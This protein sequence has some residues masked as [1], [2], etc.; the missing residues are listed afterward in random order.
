M[1]ADGSDPV[2]RVRLMI[3]EKKKV[4]PEKVVEKARAC[5]ILSTRGDIYLS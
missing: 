4:L 1:Y 3:Q 2:K 5:G